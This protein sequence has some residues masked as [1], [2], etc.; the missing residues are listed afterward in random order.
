MALI[1]EVVIDKIEVL[2]SGSIQV[3]QATRVLEDGEVLSTS[4]HRHVLQPGD[5]LTTEDPKVAA[6]AH[7]IWTFEPAPE[8]V[9]WEEETEE[10]EVVELESEDGVV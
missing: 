4:Y 3:R 9:L 5:D 7:S 1:K 8:V 10:T 2:E 6:I